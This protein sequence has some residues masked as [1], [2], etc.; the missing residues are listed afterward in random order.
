MLDAAGRELAAQLRG[1]IRR[2]ATAHA[3]DDEFDQLALAIFS[4]QYDRNI[5]YREY[6]RRRGRTP[7]DVDSWMNIP[8]VPA[9]AFREARL[10][11]AAPSEVEAIFRTSGT[12]GGVERRGEHHIADLSLYR[13][14]LFAS[15]EAFLLPDGA[16]MPVLSLVP[17]ASSLPDSSL[18]YMAAVVTERLGAGGASFVDPDSGL[19]DERL[20]EALASAVREDRPVL[21]FGTAF[22][23]VH[24][25]DRLR[26]GGT[27]F[28]LPEGTRLMD[29][30]GYKGRS[31]V[32]EPAELRAGYTAWLGVPEN[33]CVNEYGMTEM[34]SQFYEPVLREASRGGDPRRKVGPPWVRSVVV[35]S[36]QLA[37]LPFGETGLLRHVDLANIGSVSAIQ[38]EDVGRQVEG[39]FMLMGRTP[40]A[41]PRGCSIALDTLLRARGAS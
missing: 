35:D 13:D 11:A 19:D 10:A 14:T 36:E 38:T 21:L 18:S 34:L 5:I 3:T 24:L 12:T 30:G 40:G 1:M 33:R 4:Y 23:F 27:K 37:P 41:T 16:R 26:L 22:A 31:R 6:C 32:V 7:A 29:T 9:A 17:P 28:S 2:G 25:L 20:L 8:A 15:F 39:G